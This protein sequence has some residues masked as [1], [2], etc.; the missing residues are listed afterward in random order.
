MTPLQGVFR[1]LSAVT[2]LYMLLIIFRVLLSWFQGRMNGKGVEIIIKLTDPY[3]NKFRNISWLRFGFLD[4]SPVVAIALLGLVSQIFTS[5]AAT[6]HLTIGL[7]LAYIIRSAWGFISFFMD[8]LIVLMV[9]RLITVVFFSG[10]SHQFLFQ[11]DNLL[12][13]V[14]SRILGFFTDKN[15]KFSTA[16]GISA[17]VL[18]LVR[19]GLSFAIAF[20]LGYIQGL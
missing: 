5:L 17:F 15:T 19:T 6:G 3:M 18:L 7:I 9:F 16:L 4:F 1:L 13:K 2:S 14:V 12:Y 8:A 20:L 10:W 11:L